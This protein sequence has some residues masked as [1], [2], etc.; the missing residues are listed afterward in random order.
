VATLSGNRP[1]EAELIELLGPVGE[2][3]SELEAYQLHFGVRPCRYPPQ[4][5]WALTAALDVGGT[6]VLC[7]VP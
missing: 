1:G 4:E 6:G 5:E 3:A 2:Y 7:C